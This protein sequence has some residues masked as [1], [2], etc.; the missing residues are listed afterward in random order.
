MWTKKRLLLLLIGNYLGISREFS[1]FLGFVNYKNRFIPDFAKV[2]APIS[3]LLSN[4][5]KIQVGYLATMCFL[6][7]ELAVNLSTCGEV[8]RLLQALQ[9]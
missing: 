4:Q 7:L 5:K 3:N 2:A 8:I 9:D 1:S 6:H